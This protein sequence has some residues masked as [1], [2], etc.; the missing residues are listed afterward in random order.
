VSFPGSCWLLCPELSEALRRRRI[1]RNAAI[2]PIAIIEIKLTAM[3]ALAP[4]DSPLPDVLFVDALL[5][6]PSPVDTALF[7]DTVSEELGFAPPLAVVYA[8]LAGGM[9]CEA[10]VVETEV[11]DDCDAATALEYEAETEAIDAAM[12]DV[13]RTMKARETIVVCESSKAA[14]D[15]LTGFINR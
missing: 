7:D 4:V 14:L 12:S 2:A 13:F 15:E 3:P 10:G 9:D 1:R 8:P 6:D 5:L 11:A